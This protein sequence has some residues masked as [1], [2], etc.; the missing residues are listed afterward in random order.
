MAIKSRVRCEVR[1]AEKTWGESTVCSS[2]EPDVLLAIL[3]KFELRT[4]KGTATCY[5]RANADDEYQQEVPI[6]WEEGKGPCIMYMDEDRHVT[7]SIKDF[8][9][10]GI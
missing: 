5:F 2:W 9:E 8:M 10:T 4:F 1:L 6:F 3:D 7:Q